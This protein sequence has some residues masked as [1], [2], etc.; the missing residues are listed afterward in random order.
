MHTPLGAK[1]IKVNH[2]GENGAI[3][4][5]S[6][7]MF[8]AK[9]RAPSLVRSLGEFR[10]HEIKHRDIFAEELSRRA[11]PRCR[12]YHLCGLGGY[13]LGLVTGL[14]GASAIASTTVAVEAVVLRHLHSQVAALHD[15]DDDAVVA[16]QKIM[17]DEQQHHDDSAMIERAGDFWPRIIKPIVAASTESVIWLGM[18]L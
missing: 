9:W 14:I 13:L 15:I 18:R 3:N 11:V 7:Q 6:G 1:I 5:Y 2:A 4:I 8:V 16:I 10:A 12:S 17:I